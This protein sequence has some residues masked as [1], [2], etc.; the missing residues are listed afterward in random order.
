MIGRPG[1]PRTDRAGA[2]AIRD[3]R[4][5]NTTS[6]A[7][8]RSRVT[9]RA[10][11]Q[12]SAVPC[13]Q[14]MTIRL[15]DHDEE[16]AIFGSR[17]QFLRQVRDALGVKVLARNGEIRVEGDS[18]RV[19]R[20]S[21]VFEGL[22]RRYRRQRLITAA[23]R[24]RGDRRGLARRRGP[25]PAPASRSARATASSGP[26]PTARR[27]TS[28]P[29][30]RAPLVFCIGPAGTGKT[31][32]AVAA[33]V[34]DAAAGGDQEDRPGPPGGR[35]RRAPR[36]PA[37]RPGGEDQPVPPAAARRPPRPDGL[38]PAPPIHGQR[39]DRDRPAGLHAGP[40]A[41]RRGHH[42]GRGAERHRQPD[43]DVPDP[44]GRP[45]PGSS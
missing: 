31:Y 12:E 32:L 39:P 10:R 17:D 4:A 24:R 34:D 8:G 5:N 2:V 29:C 3:L 1:V 18:D 37:G 9:R 11:P 43:E 15:A 19:E 13:M 36:L 7:V 41:Q 22:R 40:D 42:H 44:D 21:R 16:L 38:R 25:E 33:A 14:A 23:G 26:G 35:G 27:G 30:R 45:T 6:A 20:A 28:G